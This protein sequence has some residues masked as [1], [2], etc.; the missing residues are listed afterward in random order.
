MGR[1][2]EER[3]ARG[4]SPVECASPTVGEGMTSPILVTKGSKA[5]AGTGCP[6]STPLAGYCPSSGTGSFRQLPP[7][8]SLACWGTGDRKPRPEWVGR[9]LK[10]LL[11]KAQVPTQPGGRPWRGRPPSSSTQRRWHQLSLCVWDPGPGH[12]LTLGGGWEESDAAQDRGP[13]RPLR[14]K[15]AQASTHRALWEICPLPG[16]PS[17]RH[18]GPLHVLAHWQAA[19]GV[20]SKKDIGG[21]ERLYRHKWAARGAHEAGPWGCGPHP[22]A[23]GEPG[24]QEEER[25]LQCVPPLL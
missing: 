8:T 7:S 21:R 19:R 23:V 16:V 13:S 20:G 1:N 18:T 15:W 3:G 25:C 14:H 17:P 6:L 11:A 5:S 24:P 10:R 12:L 2:R 9:A 4:R 22:Q